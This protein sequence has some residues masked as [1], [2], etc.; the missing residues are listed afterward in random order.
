MTIMKQS[1]EKSLPNRKKVIYPLALIDRIG[2]LCRQMFHL[3]NLYDENE[4]DITVVT[5]PPHLK[6]RTNKAVYDL[7][8]RGVNVAH[9]TDSKFMWACHSHKDLSVQVHQGVIY[10]FSR[11]DSLQLKFFE[12]FQ[13]KTPN[14]HFSLSDSEIESGR[15]LRDKFGIPQSAPTVMLHVREGG[16]LPTKDPYKNNSWRNANIENYI[17]AINYLIN[18]GFYIIRVGD[19][20]MKRF[21]NAPPQLIDAPFHPEYTAFVEPYFAAVS[22]FFIGNGSGP[23]YLATA[24][25]NP[26]LYVNANMYVTMWGH[27]KDLFVPKRV[28]SHQ[29]GRYLTYE[30]VLLS[31][32]IDFW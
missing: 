20:S 22:K 4:Y 19:K 16:Y 21:A 2:E 3:R 8:T 17:P 15:N 12:K 32:V 11:L 5:F 13:N 7:V 25:G 1:V 23:D 29:L 27:D 26:V 28:Y 10:E 14:Y 9:S 30:E 31:P 24:F 18:T 6:P